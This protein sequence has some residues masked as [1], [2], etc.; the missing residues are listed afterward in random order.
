MIKYYLYYIMNANKKNGPSMSNQAKIALNK[1]KEMGSKITNA[2]SKLKNN[3]AS[4]VNSAKKS[5]EGIKHA[6]SVC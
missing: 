3:V 1:T 4:A 5:I 6:F 2:A